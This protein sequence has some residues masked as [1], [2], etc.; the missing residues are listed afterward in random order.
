MASSEA[1]QKTTEE[2]TAGKAQMIPGGLAESQKDTCQTANDQERLNLINVFF[3]EV[4]PATW[5]RNESFLS[6]HPKVG[7]SW[8]V[9]LNWAQALK[10]GQGEHA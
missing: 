10:H 9:A 8:E 4:L 2:R 6:E 3:S 7:V 5:F 1:R